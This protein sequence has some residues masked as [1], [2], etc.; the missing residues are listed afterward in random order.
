MTL[1]DNRPIETSLPLGINVKPM[2]KHITVGAGL[3]P[4]K[5]KQIILKKKRI[6]KKKK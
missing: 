2:T 3:K 1:G 4:L 5:K 6:I